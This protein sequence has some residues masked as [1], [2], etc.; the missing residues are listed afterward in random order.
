MTKELFVAELTQEPHQEDI[1]ALYQA[2]HEHG[3]T[4]Y[5]DGQQLAT[6]SKTH[7]HIHISLYKTN[8][9]LPSGEEQNTYHLQISDP[10]P[11]ELGKPSHKTGSIHYTPEKQPPKLQLLKSA[12]TDAPPGIAEVTNELYNNITS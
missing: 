6:T 2:I 5:D 11:Q 3:K 8:K 4:V 12:P 9:Q 1:Q 10:T 7:P